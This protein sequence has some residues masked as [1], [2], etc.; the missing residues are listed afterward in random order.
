MNIEWA[1]PSEIEDGISA[2]WGVKD[3]VDTLMWRYLDHPKV[4]TEDEMHNHLHAISVLIDMH[5]EKL[6]DTYCKVYELNE[7]ASD[8]VKER[9]EQILKGFAD[10]GGSQP[11]AKKA[12]QKRK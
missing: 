7:Y 9:R 11:K 3:I 5:C 12:K 2:V 10:L 4:M 6:M 8:D 1:K